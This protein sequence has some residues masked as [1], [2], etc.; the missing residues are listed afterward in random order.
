MY[1][2]W[3]A[4]DAQAM[5]LFFR[6][7]HLDDASDDARNE[8]VA[9]AGCRVVE[10]RYVNAIGSG[11]T[12]SELR[13]TMVALGYDPLV[14]S[15]TGDTP[16]AIGNRAAAAVLAATFMDGANEAGNYADSSYSPINTPLIVSLAGNTMTDCDHWQPLALDYSV[17]QNGIP[18]PSNVQSFVGSQWGGVTPFSL[19][20]A[21]PNVP[22]IDPGPP[23]RFGSEELRTQMVELIRIQSEIDPTDPSVVDL[24]PSVRGNNSVG[25][26]S[27]T[28]HAQNPATG[29]PYPANAVLRADYGRAI[30]EFWADGPTSETPPG[31]WNVF[32]N[33][34]SDHAEATHRLAG[35]GDALGRLEWDVKMY[36]AL[37]GALHD[38]AI[39]AWGLKRV[40]DSSRAVSLIRAMATLGQSSDPLG[41][42]YDPNGLP[43]VP[44]LIEVVTPAS[45]APGERH[46]ALAP[47]VGKVAVLGWA[48]QPSDPHTQTSGVH[49]ERAERWVPYQRNTFVTPAFPGY[50]SGHSTFSR[51]GAEILAALTGSAFF[52]GGAFEYSLSPGEFVHELGPTAP[53]K[54][55][56]ATY[57]DASDEA[58]MSRL[59]GGIHTTSDDLVGRMSGRTVGLSAWSHARSFFDGTA[60]P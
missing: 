38:A 5:G 12:L 48:G 47:Y 25:T 56:W 13:G 42:S 33:A 41:T 21:S 32:G 43:L 26:N 23:P 44:G 49:W 40:Y 22:Y 2:A 28:G 29:L 7:K 46:E 36:L 39:V 60:N 35:A 17:A 30:A 4:Y 31:H 55:E 37:N 1:D 9:Y 11:A 34:V 19:V 24:S 45:A 51:A 27:G 54:L 10:A 6:E 59:W 50:I 58:G 53:F 18:L 15:T 14:T 20:R 3:A 57:F 52:P 16:S 8:A